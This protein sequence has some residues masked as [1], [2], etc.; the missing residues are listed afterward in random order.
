MYASYKDDPR[1]VMF[2]IYGQESHPVGAPGGRGGSQ[3]GERLSP[4]KPFVLG[5]AHRNLAQR[6]EAARQCVARLGLSV[7]ILLDTMDGQAARALGCRFGVTVIADQNG[8]IVYYQEGANG[9]DPA[10]ADRVLQQL[11]QRQ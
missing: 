8:N 3:G 6:A 4:E 2:L 5:D 10:G 9:I 11:L 7:P 1:V